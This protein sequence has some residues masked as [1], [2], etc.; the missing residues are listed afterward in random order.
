MTHRCLHKDLEDSR[1][2]GFDFALVQHVAP[3]CWQWPLAQLFPAARADR[4]EAV[5]LVVSDPS[6]NEL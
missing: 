6:M 5:F 1:V 2:M 3:L 4:T